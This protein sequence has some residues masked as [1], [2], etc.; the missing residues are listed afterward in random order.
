MFRKIIKP[1]ALICAALM[2]L[3]AAGCADTSWIIK[4]D[5]KS[6]PIGVYLTFLYNDREDVISQASG[7][8]SSSSGTNSSYLTLGGS[9]S[10]SSSSSSDPWSQKIDNQDAYVWVLNDAMK[11]TRDL[12]M[13]EKLCGEKN[14]SLT[15][16]EQ[17]TVSSLASYYMSAYT[18]LANNGISSD[19]YQRVIRYQYFYLPK[20]LEALYG[21][22][23]TSP[24]SDADLLS[25]YTSNFADI[26]EIALST[27]DD[28][29]N[30]LS[31]AQLKK[32]SAQADSIY[33]QLSADTS[34]FDALQAQYDPA[35]AKSNPA[36][37]IFS[38]DTTDYTS[39]FVTTA[40]GMKV[41]DVK[42]IESTDGWHIMYRVKTDTSAS[43]YDD[44]MKEQVLGKMKLKDLMS[45]LDS[46]AAKAGI[47]VNSAAV[48]HYD[49]KKLKD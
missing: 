34:K 24:V 40:F 10:S 35:M 29:G 39:D 16:S 22:N 18:G 45:Q 1:V 31:A 42:K 12:A 13:A 5:N 33:Q 47:V 44:S 25:Y 26:K 46:E 41:G 43:A 11:S 28:E 38:A 17:S 27:V 21:K 32:V 49:P 6:I 37:E 4:L 36:G 8:S 7:S 48:K 9:S 15:D 2:F 30:S 14:I 3:S 23:G 19:S 20:L